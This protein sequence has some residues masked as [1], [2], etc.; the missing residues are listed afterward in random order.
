MNRMTEEEI[1]TRATALIQTHPEKF[2]SEENIIWVVREYES[3]GALDPHEMHRW[4]SRRDITDAFIRQERERSE[5]RGGRP[6]QQQ[7]RQQRQQRQQQQHQ[8]Q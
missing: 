8:Q 2:F 3:R 7:Q 1:R 6:Q 5:A 4:L